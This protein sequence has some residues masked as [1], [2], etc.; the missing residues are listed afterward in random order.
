MTQYVDGFVLPVP[1]DRLDE[2]RRLSEAVAAIWKEHGALDY[3]EFVGDD[4]TL[5]GTRSF[6]DVVDATEADAV[7]FGWV[8][9]PSREARDLANAK[10]AADPRMAGL[11]DSSNSGFDAKRM[12]YGGFKPLA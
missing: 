6:V 7:V 11:V 10:V 3:R 8:A 5:E 12:V 4:M 9:F 2:Y 1:R